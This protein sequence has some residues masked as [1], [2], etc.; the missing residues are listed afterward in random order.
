MGK[1]IRVVQ[2]GVGA[3]GK[4]MVK[5]MLDKADI[6]LVGAVDIVNV[7]KDVG[8]VAGLDRKIGI[9][10]TDNLDAVLAKTKPD[11]IVDATFGYTKDLYPIFVKAINAK[12]NVIS[13]GAQAF[14]P[15]V[16]EPELAKEL[17]EM[18]KKNGVAIVGTGLNPGFYFDILPIFFTGVCGEVRKITFDW[19]AD[20]ANTGPT[21]RRRCG[22]G[23]PIDDAE[24]KLQ[25]GEVKLNLAYPDDVYFIANCLG[26]KLSTVREEKE[27][28]VSKVVRDHLPDYKIDPGQVYGFRH[29]C[30]GIKDGKP[31]IEIKSVS[32]IDPSLDGFQTRLAFS[33]EGDP[34]FTVDVPG[35]SL[36]KNLPIITAAHAV[37]WIPHIMKAKPGLL[38]N[39]REY[40]IVTCLPSK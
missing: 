23:F 32:A 3:K 13:I 4:I 33:I 20:M 37:N 28:L 22:Y 1:K 30:Y 8:E 2:H 29:D 9:P 35:L 19:V 25:T 36:G 16:N 39:A 14:N 12:V 27:F 18:A 5:V 15:W 40:P 34:S 24:R 10:I 31:V 26:W 21:Y 7:G 17:D 6:E 38:T 11:V